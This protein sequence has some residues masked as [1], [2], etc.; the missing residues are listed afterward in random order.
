MIIPNL[1]PFEQALADS[2]SM[3]RNKLVAQLGN[4][5][6]LVDATLFVER[7]ESAKLR[8]R[9]AELEKQIEDMKAPE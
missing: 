4:D 2:L 5:L 1:G 6:A 3:Q 9:I 7:A 8:E